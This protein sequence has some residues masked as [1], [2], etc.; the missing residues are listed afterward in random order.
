M[1]QGN[2]KEQGF[3]EVRVKV[4]ARDTL[5]VGFWMAICNDDWKTACIVKDDDQ[6]QY[7]IKVYIKTLC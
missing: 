2:D 3:L 5:N 4:Y 7:F 6:Q 1:H